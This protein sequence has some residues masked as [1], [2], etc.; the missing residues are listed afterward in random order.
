MTKKDPVDRLN[1]GLAIT[2]TRQESKLKKPLRDSV[3]QV[4]TLDAH[5]A[6]LSY[7]SLV[8]RFFDSLH[9]TSRHAFLVRVLVD[10]ASANLSTSFIIICIYIYTHTHIFFPFFLS[11]QNYNIKYFFFFFL[12]R[13]YINLYK[14]RVYILFIQGTKEN[15]IKNIKII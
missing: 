1:R 7:F 5:Q 11:Y 10:H 6:L 8:S 2:D 14:C 12:K 13:I 9:D 15:I 4:L 3:T